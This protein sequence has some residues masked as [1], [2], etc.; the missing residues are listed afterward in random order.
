[1]DS[2]VSSGDVDT[3]YRATDVRTGKTVALKVP[4]PQ[5]DADLTFVERF[6]R[7]GEIGRHLDHPDILKVFPED[8]PSQ[9]YMVMEWVDGKLLRQILDEQKKLPQDR[10]VKIAFGICQALSYIHNHGIVHRNLRPEHVMV[11]AQDHVK[12]IDFGLAAQTGARR[13]TFTK[14]S[15]AMSSPEYISPEQVQGK[16]SDARSD[17]YSLGVM[18]YEM[19]TARKPFHGANAFE[20]MNDRLLE[21][22]VP[23]RE[24][25]PAISPHLQ[26]VIYRAMEREPQY[27][28]PNAHDFAF[29]LEHLDQV[30]VAARPELQD[31][32]KKRS[33]VTRKTLLFAAMVFVPIVIFALLFYFA[34]R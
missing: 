25:D 18:L 29:D 10:A 22:P 14:L 21:N 20:V 28:Y 3:V 5:M 30:G 26:E 17:L 2:V 4:H 11:D 16:R 24:I 12:L 19:V 15:Q 8:H 23:P 13:I 27:R 6:Q 31:W 7:A 33:A 34:R 9:N 32:R 1:M